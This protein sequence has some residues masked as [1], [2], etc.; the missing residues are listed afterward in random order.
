MEFV[1]NRYFFYDLRLLGR[2]HFVLGLSICLYVVVNINFASN[3]RSV[4]TTLI[5]FWYAY[6][7]DQ[8]L[9]YGI[10]VGHLVTFTMTLWPWMNPSMAWCFTLS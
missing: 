7:L 10:S 6:S 5:I 8:A 9:P 4:L 1:H 2:G 3:F